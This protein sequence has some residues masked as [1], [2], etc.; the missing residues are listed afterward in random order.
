MATELCF[1]TK[2]HLCFFLSFFLSLL[3]LKT[4]LSLHHHQT[5]PSPGVHELEQE[6]LPLYLAFSSTMFHSCISNTC[7]FVIN[8]NCGYFHITLQLLHVS[9]TIASIHHY[10]NIVGYSTSLLA[11]DF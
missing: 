2:Y 8:G 9:L 5:L 1:V 3:S 11:L 4:W 6:K 7:Y 10:F